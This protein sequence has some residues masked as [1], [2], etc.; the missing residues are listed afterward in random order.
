MFAS[1]KHGKAQEAWSDNWDNGN[2]RELD[3][4]DR[5]PDDNDVELTG[6]GNAEIDGEG[7]MT[8]SGDAPRFRVVDRDYRDVNVTVYAMRIN[9]DRELSFQGFVIGAR[10]QH[11][12]NAECYANTYYARVTYDGRLSF[13]K[14][15]FHGVSGGTVQFPDPP[16][17]EQYFK[18]GV[19]RNQWIGLRFVVTTVDNNTAVRLDMYLDPPGGGTDWQKVLED[20]DTGHWETDSPEGTCDG[21]PQNKILLSPGFVFL[22]ND[23]LG[24][25]K[26]KDFTI[27]E[28]GA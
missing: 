17:T 23:G 27:S 8:L 4:G 28:E 2:D 5:D 12:T 13:E 1:T 9:E 19:P 26:Y 20:K 15:L 21:Y 18:D 6:I 7:V 11:Y 25:A 3:F 14:E 24:E 22:R 10:S 16:D